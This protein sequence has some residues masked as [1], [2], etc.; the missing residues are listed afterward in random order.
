[1]PFNKTYTSQTDRQTYNG[2][3]TGI[4]GITMGGGTI[5][6]I[7]DPIIIGATPGMIGI[8]EA[9]AIFIAAKSIFGFFAAGSSS[10]LP[11]STGK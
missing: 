7:M 10:S 8:I 6:G 5:P 2:C 11:T 4:P 3:A 1:M 9:A